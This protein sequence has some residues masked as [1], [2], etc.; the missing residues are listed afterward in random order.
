MKY[1][2]CLT[3][4]QMVQCI[5]NWCWVLSMYSL[6]VTFFIIMVCC[7]MYWVGIL[8]LHLQDISNSKV[9]ECSITLPD[10]SYPDRFNTLRPRQNW[11]HFA[12]DMFKCIVLNENVWMPIEISLKFVAK[13]IINNNPILFKIM[14][15]R[16]PG[17]KPLSEPMMISWLTHIS[18]VYALVYHEYKNFKSCCFGQK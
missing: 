4:K 3:M 10:V 8:L 15:W 11:H 13:G 17:E 12:D 18:I 16:R 1:S 5:L 6:E 2:S 14:A 9:K 7:D